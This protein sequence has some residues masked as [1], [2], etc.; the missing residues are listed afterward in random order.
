MHFEMK[1]LKTLIHSAMCTAVVLVAVARAEDVKPASNPSDSK[2]VDP[3][4]TWTWSVPARNGGPDRTNTLTLKLEGDKVTGK[5]TTP[6]RDGQVR[7]SA[8]D[9]GKVKGSDLS[10]SITREFNGNSFTMKYSGKVAADSIQGKVEFD[11]DG[12]TQSRDWHAAR[13]AEKGEMPAKPESSDKAAP[14]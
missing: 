7:E 5:L 4:G 11:R 12:E 6:G 3:S 13:Q 9:D 10:F 1:P 8:V 2:P 14:K